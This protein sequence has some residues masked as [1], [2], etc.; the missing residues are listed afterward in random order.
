MT[1]EQDSYLSSGDLG[2]CRYGT[3]MKEADYNGDR[4][5]QNQM[6]GDEQNSQLPHNGTAHFPYGKNIRGDDMANAPL[7]TISDEIEQLEAFRYAFTGKDIERITG[8]IALSEQVSKELS[9]DAQFLNIGT[10]GSG[11]DWFVPE[12]VLFGW[13]RGLLFKLVKAGVFTLGKDQLRWSFGSLRERGEWEG[14]PAPAYQYGESMGFVREGGF[15]FVFPLAKLISELPEISQKLVWA[16]LKDYE[17]PKTRE[18]RLSPSL[19]S[20]VYSGL[21]A[22][23]S[24]ISQTIQARE[25]FVVFEFGAGMAKETLTLK[26][27]GQKLGVTRERIRQIEKKFWQFFDDDSGLAEEKMKEKRL[28]ILEGMLTEYMKSKGSMI[29]PASG[30][31]S[32]LY[33][34]V[35][36]CNGISVTDLPEELGYGISIPTIRNNRKG[37]LEFASFLNGSDSDWVP[38]EDKAVL[39]SLLNKKE[40][41]VVTKSEKVLRALRDL[42]RPSHF[43]EVHLR[44]QE[45]FPDDSISEHSLHAKLSC[46]GLGQQQ[47]VWM[48]AK[49][50][51]GLEEWG[52]ERPTKP[53]MDQVADIVR[54]GFGESGM[55]VSFSFIQKVIKDLRQILNPNSVLIAA[56]LNPCVKRLGNDLYMPELVRE[57][58]VNTGGEDLLILEENCQN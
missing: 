24:R 9:L 23:E 58:D 49:G 5:S 35:M 39:R 12:K 11:E 8:S 4:A 15:G 20:R 36:K 10:P 40:K 44:Y 27:I 30:A 56:N 1:A 34:F 14:I 43:Q 37:L 3:G 54:C 42:G 31:R 7:A 57:E 38:A 50:I 19:S 26:D 46:P 51:Y 48:G 32:S 29:F 25:G 17:D 55:P 22:F 33:R 41:Q 47:I 2:A 45:L 16:I 52:N 13:W 21:A 18:E 53:L 28:P 6:V